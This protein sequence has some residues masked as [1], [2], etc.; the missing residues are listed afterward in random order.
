VGLSL[1]SPT[2]TLDSS[3]GEENEVGATRTAAATA[4]VPQVKS[5]KGEADLTM[6][7]SPAKDP[8]TFIHAGNETDFGV[9][10]AF[11]EGNFH[12]AEY[13]YAG[14]GAAT[15]IAGGLVNDKG[16]SSSNRL[17]SSRGMASP[18]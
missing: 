13:G 7:H 18:P 12:N 10:S 9:V 16:E 2:K 3:N 17:T 5:P 11:G 14:K 4:E 1:G 15:G 8:P 6:I